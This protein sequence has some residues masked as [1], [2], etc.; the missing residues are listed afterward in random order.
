M[1]ETFVVLAVGAFVWRAQPNQNH[2]EVDIARGKLATFSTT[3]NSTAPT[4]FSFC[5]VHPMIFFIFF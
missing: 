2:G 1:N 3:E 5:R 4:P